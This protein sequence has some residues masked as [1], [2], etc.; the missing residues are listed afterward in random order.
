MKYKVAY[1]SYTFPSNNFCRKSRF[2]AQQ[3]IEE[4]RSDVNFVQ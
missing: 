2:G 3:R 1:I 4:R